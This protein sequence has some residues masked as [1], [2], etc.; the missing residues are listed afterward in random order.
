MPSVW[1]LSR[2][3]VWVLINFGDGNNPG[4]VRKSEFLQPLERPICGGSCFRSSVLTRLVESK[5]FCFFTK[6]RMSWERNLWHMD[7]GP[8]GLSKQLK[9]V[10]IGF[11][12]PTWRTYANLYHF[13]IPFCLQS[14]RA[15]DSSAHWHVDSPPCG[16]GCESDWAVAGSHGEETHWGARG[17][18]AGNGD[19]IKTVRD[20][21]VIQTWRTILGMSPLMFTL[22][23]RRASFTNC[24]DLW[25]VCHRRGSC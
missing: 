4:F 16:S 25:R 22:G 18:V 15:S 1:I 19:E 8:W 14:L 2:G 9:L 24:G 3:K 12:R 21:L 17:E 10:T 5:V 7:L 11:Y 6:W 13:R 23:M 20:W